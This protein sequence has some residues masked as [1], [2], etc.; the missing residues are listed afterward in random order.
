MQETILFQ[1]SRK[2]TPSSL[3]TSTDFARL[4]NICS[5]DESSRTPAFVID[6]GTRTGPLST[7]TARASQ[8]YWLAFTMMIGPSL[9]ARWRSENNGGRRNHKRPG[10]SRMLDTTRSNS[11]LRLHTWPCWLGPGES[12]TLRMREVRRVNPFANS[13]PAGPNAMTLSSGERRGLSWPQ[14]LLK[15]L[16]CIGRRVVAKTS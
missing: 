4:V 7:K 10:S 2:K 14:K 9:A 6:N 13:S 1:S 12:R 3:I 8:P 11:E 16:D 5:C 15:K